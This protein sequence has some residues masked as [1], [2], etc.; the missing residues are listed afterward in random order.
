MIINTFRSKLLMLIEETAGRIF[1]IGFVKKNG[2]Y[3]TMKAR[4]GVKAYLRTDNKISPAKKPSNP[5]VC[6]FDMDKREYRLVNL[7]TVDY[8]K[9]GDRYAVS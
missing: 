2:E 9:C 4:T 8:M 5:Y 6:L 3:R 7:D 1:S